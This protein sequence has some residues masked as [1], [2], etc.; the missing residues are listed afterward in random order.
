MA[1]ARRRVF[2]DSASAFSTQSNVFSF[3]L[4]RELKSVRGVRLLNAVIPRS[5]YNIS[6]DLATNSVVFNDG[7]DYTVSLTAGQYT[8]SALA[9][10]LQ[11]QLNASGSSVTFTVTYSTTTLLFT[12]AGDSAITLKWASSGKLGTLLGFGTSNS[13]S[14]TSHTA[15]SAA[16]IT[17]DTS[18][19]VTCASLNNPIATMYL[20][21]YD[22][23]A[24]ARIFV[25][26]DLDGTDM[27]YF[28]EDP[29]FLPID[30]SLVNTI[31]IYLCFHDKSPVLFN[32]RRW[33]LLLE[34]DVIDH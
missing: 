29:P 24:L 1:M 9:T 28:T 27:E 26:N 18:I 11:T 5:W 3:K 6:S 2:L 22:Y 7:S 25:G 20:T 21:P 30:I 14:A 8:A 12:I 10:H 17:Y 32:G 34:F 31:D 19:Y 33:K 4:P 15:T 16:S 23:Q 13:S